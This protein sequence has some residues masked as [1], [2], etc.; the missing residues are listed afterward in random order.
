MLM[1]TCQHN[2]KIDV[3]ELVTCPNGQMPTTY[4]KFSIY[5]MYFK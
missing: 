1:E 3:N 4:C 5:Y 2:F